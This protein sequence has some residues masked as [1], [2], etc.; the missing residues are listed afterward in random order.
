MT[1][2]LLV[3]SDSYSFTSLSKDPPLWLL[4][5]RVS[6]SPSPF[7]TILCVARGK[8]RK[9]KGYWW[10]AQPMGEPVTRLRSERR[11]SGTSG[12]EAL[13]GLRSWHH[14]LHWD[15]G[16]SLRAAFSGRR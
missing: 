3:N 16:E 7:P 2:D 13:R 15:R 11:R 10:R 6:S 4:R 1:L 14:E 8:S 9:S 12:L 5:M